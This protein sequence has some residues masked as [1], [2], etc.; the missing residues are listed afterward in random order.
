MPPRLAPPSPRGTRSRGRAAGIVER[1]RVRVPP[2]VLR[3]FHGGL[4]ALGSRRF[5]VGSS[6]QTVSSRQMRSDAVPARGDSSWPGR[7]T[8]G[9][10]LEATDAA[11]R[12]SRRSTRGRARPRP[13]HSWMTVRPTMRARPRDERGEGVEAR[14]A[15]SPQVLRRRVRLGLAS[16]CG[17]LRPCGLGAGLA[18]QVIR[19][20]RFENVELWPGPPAALQ[21]VDASPACVS[22][23]ART[24][25]RAASPRRPRRRCLSRSSSFS[26]PARPERMSTWLATGTEAGCPFR[27]CISRLLPA[28]GETSSTCARANG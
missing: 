12:L 15:E 17:A 7:S 5:A 11:A 18:R 13:R 22:R 20:V 21:R 16:A 4:T 3:V 8:G 25:P 1:R 2:R 14:H 28:R 23:C 26:W 24:W 10:I 27:T 19:P 9:S 6:R